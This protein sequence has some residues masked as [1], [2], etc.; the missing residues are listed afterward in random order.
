MLYTCENCGKTGVDMGVDGER[1]VLVCP[2]CGHERA[3][4][5]LPLFGIGG[6]SGTGKTAVC[7]ALAGKLPGVICLD[8]DLF[9]DSRFSQEAPEAF[10]EYVLRIA[11]NIAQ[12]G[13]ALAIF[14]AGFGIPANLENCPSRRMFSQI[15]YLALWCEDDELER[16]LRKRPEAADG[17]IR[18]MKGFNAFFRFGAPGNENGPTA[19]RL[20]TSGKTPEETAAVV[21]AWIEK[22]S[23][24]LC[25]WTLA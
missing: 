1:S 22:N 13:A 12:S 23:K 10:Y 2:A 11:A 9:W 6:A 18:S 14:N 16:R 19:E 7:R 17:F 15:H 20:D 3:F 5:R 25:G 21:G 24:E 8:G 4:H